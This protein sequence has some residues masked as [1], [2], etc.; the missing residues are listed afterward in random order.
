MQRW[1]GMLM[2][3]WERNVTE[4]KGNVAEVRRERSRRGKK[5]NVHT[6][7]GRDRYRRE[8]ERCGDGKRSS[9]QRERE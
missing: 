2:L 3:R 1:E 6:Q 5:G 7:V 8:S 9:M 4:G